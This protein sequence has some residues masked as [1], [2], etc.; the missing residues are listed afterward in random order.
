MMKKSLGVA[1]GFI[2]FYPLVSGASPQSYSIDQTRYFATP[3]VEKAELKQR[4][5]EASAFPAVA[6]E[7]PKALYNYLH[8]ADVLHAQFLRHAAYLH[9]RVSQDIDDQADA[10]ASEQVDEADG[11]VLSNGAVALHTLGGDAFSKAASVNPA[12]NRYAYLPALAERALAHGLPA[13]QQRILDALAGPAASNLW[14]LYQK[15][16][17]STPFARIATTDGELDAIKDGA[18]LSLSPNRA[19]RQAAWQAR[20][21]GYVSRAD[22]Y[23]TILLGVVRLND[24]T[25]KLEHFPDA[26]TQVYLSRNLDRK[27]VTEALGA[28]ESHAELF[29]AYQRLR[30]LHVAASTG[31]ADVHSWDLS[32]PAPG[33]TVPHLTLDQSRVLVLSALAPL[34]ADYVE[35]FRQLLDPAN[36]R[37]DIASEQGMRVNGGFSIGAP[38]VPSGLFIENYGPGLINDTRVI[39]HEGGHAIHRQLMT[40][41]GIASF[42]T[43]GPNWMFEAFAILNEFLLYDHLYQ[44][45]TDLKTRAYY[46][47]WLLGDMTFTLF[48]SAEEAMLEQSIYDS[49]IAGRIRDTADFD[50]L[51]LSI[52]S[53]FEIWPA[54]EPQLIHTWISKRLMFQ[55]PLYQVNYLYAGLLATKMFD[56]V[57]HDPVAFQRRY[58]ELLR[59]GFYAPPEQLLG[60][61]F[62]RELSQRELVDDSMNILQQRIQALAEIYKKLDAKH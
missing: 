28:I 49:V 33:F 7:D 53:K 36:G 32:L 29:K 17:R 30:A 9:L 39:I 58:S 41:A 2:C 19:V 52:W 15:T 3:E 27:R 54:S 6:P 55:D 23:A 25:A 26:P 14:T 43:E 56:M 42:Y 47:E 59:G 48:G 10:D 61:F 12:L 35:H 44:T 16:L 22:I 5:E 1:L 13:D 60:K 50:A 38:G 62:G 20:W 24:R 45:S 40:E 8:R 11:Q 18:V 31:I 57:R 51:T 37:M 46:L 34:G 4:I 21:D